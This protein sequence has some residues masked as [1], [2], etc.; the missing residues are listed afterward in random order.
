MTRPNENA[1]R[2]LAP[3]ELALPAVCGQTGKLFVMVADRRSRTLLEIVRAVPIEDEPSSASVQVVRS[4]KQLQPSRAQIHSRT[5]FQQLAMTATVKIGEAY[6]GCPYCRARGYFRCGNCE[7]FS[8]WTKFN[9]RLHADHEDVWC[10]GCGSWR[11][12]SNDGGDSSLDFTAYGTLG[13]AAN[14]APTLSQ[15]RIA[16]ASSDLTS[17]PWLGGSRLLH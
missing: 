10:S 4:E 11:C 15:R 2:L 5:S 7:L 8:C 13:N 12:T 16:R 3:N 6:R 14:T 9:R 1:E 17:L